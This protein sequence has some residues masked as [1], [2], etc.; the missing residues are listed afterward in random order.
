MDGS[1]ACNVPSIGEGADF[2][3]ENSI[4]AVTPLFCLYCVISWCGFINEILIY[5][6]WKQK[7][8]ELVII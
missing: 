1:I 8:L 4:Q 7:N 6:K 3:D 2:R 5:Q